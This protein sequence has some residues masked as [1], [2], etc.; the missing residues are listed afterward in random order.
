MLLYASV[1][2]CLIRLTGIFCSARGGGFM[3]IRLLRKASA[4]TALVVTLASCSSGGPAPSADAQLIAAL[5]A[6]RQAI[7]SATSYSAEAVE[8]VASPVQLRK[9]VS[10]AKLSGEDQVGR[11]NA[12]AAIVAAVENAL[13]SRAEFSSVQ[14][15]SVA[16]NHPA[17]S[18]GTARDSH[19]EDVL[20][21]RKGL[22]KAFSHHIT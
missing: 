12:A 17:Q 18:E 3:C 2:M 5:P 21:F 16:I 19:T 20:E 7:T 22:N 9:L 6:V 13:A 1:L 4:L 8:F 14:I 15:I 11:E 10:D